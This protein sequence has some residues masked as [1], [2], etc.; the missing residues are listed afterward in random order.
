MSLNTDKG[1][2]GLTKARAKQAKALARHE[3]GP[4]RVEPAI[5]GV[6][7]GIAG[8]DRAVA[9]ID[10]ALLSNAP[11]WPRCRAWTIRL[12]RHRSL[13]SPGRSRNWRSS[14]PS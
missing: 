8:I 3:Q 13:D 7:K 5:A 6:R 1:I 9:G 14:A 10:A 11:R 12:R 4:G 2:A